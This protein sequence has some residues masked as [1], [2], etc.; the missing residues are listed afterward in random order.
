MAGRV[1]TKFVVILSAILIL[2]I[3]GLVGLWFYV[4]RVDPAEHIAR[5]DKYAAAG[6]YEKAVTYYGRALRERKTDVDLIL[7]FADAKSQ[8]LV[9][10]FRV[11]QNNITSQID[12]YRNAL[13]LSP[14]NEKALRGL[15]DMYTM[16]GR[17]M[18]SLDGW[19][20]LYLITQPILRSRPDYSL[21][22]RYR[23]IAQVNRLRS[24]PLSE[25]EI[26]QTLAD[27]ELARRAYP[28]DPDIEY[29]IAQWHLLEAKR[30]NKPGTAPKRIEQHISDAV[31]LAEDIASR[32]RDDPQ[33]RLYHV[34]ILIEAGRT[35]EAITALIK[36]SDELT[37]NPSAPSVILEVV[38][39]LGSPLMNP[40]DG[41]DPNNVNKSGIQRGEK[42]MLAAA[43]AYP[44]DLRIQIFLGR[45]Q[46]SLGKTEDATETYTRVSETEVKA[47]SQIAYKAVQ[48]KRL[49][50]AQH[51]DLKVRAAQQEDD[52]AM[53]AEML[54]E[55][56]S[57]I[58]Q[59]RTAGG[60]AS[61]SHMLEGKVAMARGEWAVALKQFDT[62]SSL[63][64]D[65]NPELLSLSSSACVKLGELGAAVTR[66]ERLVELAPQYTQ[67]RYQL[68][69]LYLRLAQSD[70]AAMQLNDVL[71][72]RPND[73][74][75]RRLQAVLYGQIGKTDKAIK[76]YNQLDPQKNREL[77]LPLA[78]L[79]SST[80]QKDK[81]FTMLEE[82][83]RHEPSNLAILREMIRL[84]P[85]PQDANDY[86][87]T[88]RRAGADPSKIDLIA[89]RLNAD[90][91]RDVV[92]DVENLVKNEEDDVRRHLARHH[93]Y[94]RLSKF[95]EAREALREAV[96]A[97][98]NDAGVVE[99][100]FRM[101]LIDKNWNQAETLAVKAA[102]LN[103]DE[104][105]GTFIRGQLEMARGRS[106]QAITEF[107][108]GL[109]LRPV[110]S[111]GWRMYGD[112]QRSTGDVVAAITAYQRALDQRPDNVQAISN[113]A[114]T[115][116]SA[117]RYDEALEQ[118]RR[119]MQFRAN[120]DALR[121]RYLTYEQDHGSKERALELRKKIAEAMPN[122]T[123][124]RR[125]LAILYAS[126]RK[127]PEAKQV[128]EKLFDY[129][130]RTLQNIRTYAMVL[131]FAGNHDAGGK[132]LEDHIKGLGE[133]ATTEDW[134]SIGVYYRRVG[135]IDKAIFAYRQAMDIE[136]DTGDIAARALADLLF[137]T[138]RYAEATDV[139]GNLWRKEMTN[140][141]VGYRYVE[142]L[143][144]DLK[145][146]VAEDTLGRV[147]EKSG[148]DSSAQLLYSLIAQY[149]KDYNK[150]MNHLDRAVKLSPDRAI[151][152]F[153]RANVLWRMDID[154]EEEAIAD[155]QKAL[156]LE[157]NL[158]SARH[159]MA[160]LYLL[161]N[162]PRQA[163][164]QLQEVIKRRPY[165]VTTRIQLLNLYLNH[166]EILAAKTLMSESSEMFPSDARW[167]RLRAEQ[168]IK[169]KN[170]RLAIKY[171]QEAFSREPKEDVLGA[172]AVQLLNYKQANAAVSVLEQKKSMTMADPGLRAIYGRMLLQ[173]GKAAEGEAHLT[174][175]FDM[176]KQLSHVFAVSTQ[177]VA[178]Y[179]LDEAT[180]KLEQLSKTDKSAWTQVSIARQ[181]IVADQ[182]QKA[183]NRLNRTL[184]SIQKEDL[185]AFRGL[186]A[187]ALHNS[188][189]HEEAATVYKEIVTDNSKNFAALNNLAYLLATDLNRPKDALTYAEKAA[190]E[191]PND[192]QILDTLGWVQYQ[193]G[194][195]EKAYRTLRR[196]VRIKP[197]AANSLHFAKVLVAMGE[198]SSAEQI[199][200]SAK[201]LAEKEENQELLSQI[202]GLQEELNG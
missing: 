59:F 62:S 34:N 27:L 136:K 85:T 35:D 102:E 188:G 153:E 115:L 70:R 12:Y 54:A 202:T 22:L 13:D 84:A 76:V 155:L 66:L 164:R 187:M 116:D 43:K 91:N 171:L 97:G 107:T 185:E 16:I 168:A 90:G 56:E 108:N 3:V 199:L 44:T 65:K 161:V 159:L 58:R 123:T 53:R 104:A 176:S 26:E 129:E 125:G 83:F 47:V 191:K 118:Y 86:V 172:L 122:D 36:L 173:T 1:N 120:N 195:Q 49:A 37:A 111:E 150:A 4:N 8:L 151:V 197:M 114:L 67:G 20:Q 193:S 177:M 45:I 105:N 175:S 143:V 93:F 110:Y 10:D 154:R 141:L 128:L 184:P 95:D 165:D 190:D 50:I 72:M 6:Q 113:L 79:Y 23:G 178:A 183:A 189:N 61:L 179:G 163:I 77:V 31:M 162:N 48:L 152:Y 103:A 139:Y 18:N 68:I 46:E 52:S 89:G 92:Q 87:E 130:G 40:D 63:K 19:N 29:H 71:R 78:R 9:S 33:A 194:L 69:K 106:S 198:R 134:I 15:A 96:K 157:P 14:S 149:H 132:L 147:I 100:Q 11:A 186:L 135:L 127:F 156:D 82:Q 170:H 81:A 112:A 196:S 126:M 200:V 181:E 169:E 121:E 167:P 41:S 88:A 74:E 38:E 28:D 109:K 2:F 64:D 32:H 17:E 137:D 60:E 146:D 98:P 57:L 148:D 30:L 174:G 160:R 80:G 180:V 182:P 140:A 51:A 55:V 124:N 94:W 142:A 101:A 144:R 138:G 73:Y 133:E 201:R 21:A 99:A 117:A 5:A 166:D 192:P 42:L 7:K 119:A 145:L 25:S 24:V 39:R 131:A 158:Q 75:G